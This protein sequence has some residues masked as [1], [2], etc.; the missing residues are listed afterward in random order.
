MPDQPDQNPRT[1]QPLRG[2]NPELYGGSPVE[3]TYAAPSIAEGPLGVPYSPPA[4]VPIEQ[5]GVGLQSLQQAA[6]GAQ[7]AQQSLPSWM[8]GI[9]AGAGA[10]WMGSIYARATAPDFGEEDPN[11]SPAEVLQTVQ[12]Q[13]RPEEIRWIQ[14][15]RNLE[16]GIWR[17]DRIEQLREYAGITSKRP[18]FA[19]LGG[20]LTDPLLFTGG[21][22]ITLARYANAGRAAAAAGAGA[23]GVA[24]G[25]YAQGGAPISDAEVIVGG[26]LEA[27]AAGVFGASR[28]A[29][30]LLPKV[31]PGPHGPVLV[32]P[33]ASGPNAGQALA[34]EEVRSKAQQ[35]GDKLQWNVHKTL[36]NWGAPKEVL[37]LLDDNSDLS[38]VSVE[39]QKRAIH[40]EFVAGYRLVE[41]ELL[42]EMAARGA[43]LRAR[44]MSPGKANAVQEAITEE[45]RSLML[46]REQAARQGVQK[47]EGMYSEGVRRMADRF[48]ALNAKVLHEMQAAGVE[49]AELVAGTPGWLS[50]RWSAKG[51]EDMR[52]AFVRQGMDTKKAM[53]QVRRF[54]ERS[55]HRA[56][57]QWDQQLAYDVA[58]A[59]TDRA[60]RKGYF[61]DT[62]LRS[63]Q[64]AQ[65]VSEMR[66]ILIAEGLSPQRVQRALN[67]LEGKVTESGK[68]SF[69]KPRLDL[70]YDLGVQIGNETWTVSKLFDNDIISHT[71]QYL[72][73]AAGWSALAREGIKTSNDIEKMRNAL[74]RSQKDATQRRKAVGMFDE[75]MNDLLGRPAG[76]QMNEVERM[77]NGYTR[78]VALGNSGLWQVTEFANQAALFGA[79][80][81]LKHALREMPVLRKLW[82]EVSAGDVQT[83]TRLRDILMRE[84]EQDLR[85]RPFTKYM[86]DNFELP[87]AHKALL[88]TQQAEQMVP[89][90][91]GM[92]SIHAWQSRTTANLMQD[93][94]QE[95]AKGKPKALQHLSRYGITEDM[96]RAAKDPDVQNW[97]AGLWEQMRAPMRTMMDEAVMFNRIGDMPYWAKYDKLGKFI[98]TFRS[99]TLGVH[100][101]IMAGRMS[102]EGGAALLLLLHQFPLAVLMQQARSVANG[103][104]PLD[105]QTAAKKALGV[106]GGLGMFTEVSNVLSGESRQFG[107]PGLIGIDKAYKLGSAVAS[108]DP[109][110]VGAAAVGAVPLLNVLPGLKG[111]QQQ[112]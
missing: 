7:E 86:Q 8:A 109:G 53:Q 88:W 60:I 58:N 81:T 10:G 52:D 80:K 62:A 70:D 77:F 43:G 72:Q 48:D 69:L 11:F 18:G 26:L 102:R 6:A 89:Y 97:P 61:E 37:R 112:L 105:M 1:G 101:K 40:T 49:G 92:R 56:N 36:K 17:K 46:R 79:L 14:E 87:E 12:H 32:P 108:G 103:E 68:A 94:L 25:L 54:V 45:L 110:N 76:A 63:H 90:V 67:V 5:L 27:G 39:A 55:L 107:A 21:S 111:I 66:D 9:K 71:D 100:N 96:A 57:P 75:V 33:A 73:S 59:V 34:Q 91:N 44:L 41:R 99:F 24:A 22:S 50:R 42:D 13:L 95:A 30:Q 3:Q 29:Q 15:S 20:L 38:K 104:G 74:T 2:P 98:F 35:L 85:M 16:E 4:P 84:S 93:L 47:S 28:T 82:Q 19:M 64:G 23:S 65:A 83:S 106:M 78:M 31:Q 51:I